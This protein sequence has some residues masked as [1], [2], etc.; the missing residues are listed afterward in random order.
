MHSIEYGQGGIFMSA[1]AAICDI[2]RTRLRAAHRVFAAYMVPVGTARV[3]TG[4]RHC[5]VLLSFLVCSLTQQY[6]AIRGKTTH[7]GAERCESSI[8]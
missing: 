6:M 8:T 7:F 2:F 5:T 1:M 3:T 4:L